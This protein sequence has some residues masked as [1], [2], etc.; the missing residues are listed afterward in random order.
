MSVI[1]NSL[2]TGLI[3]EYLMYGNANDTSGNSNNGTVTTPTLTTDMLGRSDK[4]YLFDL[5]NSDYIVS[6]STIS[7]ST[8]VLSIS[9]FVN[10]TTLS[11]G[12][13]Y[14]LFDIYGD[15]NNR[16]GL[17]QRHQSNLLYVYKLIG[18]EGARRNIW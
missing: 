7:L 10:F 9:G 18:G 3:T 4:A 11:P 16:M 15:S 6:S 1:P 13:N 5:S 12:T 17:Y 8:S 14:A 2:R